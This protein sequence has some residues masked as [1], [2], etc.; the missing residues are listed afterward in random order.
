[1]IKAVVVPFHSQLYVG[2]FQY[3]CFRRTRHSGESFETVLIP[4]V[5]VVAL[6]CSNETENRYGRRSIQEDP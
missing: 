2:K 1:M 6:H 5:Q 4:P 3:I